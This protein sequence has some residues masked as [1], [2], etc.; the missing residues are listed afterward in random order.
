MEMSLRTS[1]SVFLLCLKSV[2]VSEIPTHPE[3]KTVQNALDGIIA[4]IEYVK[5]AI[6]SF[7]AIDAK[8]PAAD[9]T[10]TYIGEDYNIY[11]IFLLF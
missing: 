10:I 6:T 8:A 2:V 5:P 11:Q 3:W 1:P 7:T 4:K 9:K